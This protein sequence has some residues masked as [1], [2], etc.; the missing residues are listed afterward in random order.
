[1]RHDQTSVVEWEGKA[2]PDMS[3]REDKLISS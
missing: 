1:L 3:D 2:L